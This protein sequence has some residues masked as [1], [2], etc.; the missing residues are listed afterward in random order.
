MKNLI[1]IFSLIVLLFSILNNTFTTDDC[2][3]QW[4]RMT[5]APDRFI[6]CFTNYGNKIFSG[7]YQNG[8]YSCSGDTMW[9]QTMLNNKNVFSLAARD[10]NIFAGTDLNGVWLSTDNGIN[11]IQSS[12]N[13]K[14]VQSLLVNG[15]N[16]FAGT[17][18]TPF[19]YAGIYIS[20]NNGINW[21]KTNFDTT[22]GV[23]S[24]TV[25]GN[26]IFAGTYQGVYITSNNGINWVQTSLNNQ[27]VL[28]LTTH[29]NILFAGT[30]ANGIFFTTDNGNNWA[31][32]FI[33]SS[34]VY[35]LIVN[36]NNIF[37]GTNNGI[38]LSTN[39][40]VNWSEKNQGFV[41]TPVVDAL[42]I[43]NNFIYAGTSTQSIWRRSLSDII[44]IQKISENVPE[45]YSLGQNYPNPFNS[46]TNVKFQ[47][48]NGGM[49][50][51]T[52]YDVLGKEVITL[53]NEK[54]APGTYE[55]RFDGGNLSS[56]IYFYRMTTGNFVQ[57]KKMLMIK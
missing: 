5:T 26:Y 23:R 22:I 17:Y 32:T 18:V 46:M 10:S 45:F 24:F 41:T 42:I 36:S 51:I 52:V 39:N 6:Y 47:M 43:V 54:L 48:L 19:S 55:I 29:G 11:W 31:Q 34:S 30:D 20:T 14:N 53:V 28:S 12:L 27:L 57:T 15:N 50:K 44:G 16:I 35:S 7:T 13:N 1:K 56:G 37:A 38:Y 9:I 33:N 8:I 40:G 21:N 2:I 4:T 3:A 49:A 25:S